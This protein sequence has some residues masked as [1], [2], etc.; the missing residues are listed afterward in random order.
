MASTTT[1][2]SESVITPEQLADHGTLDTLWIAV[3]GRVYDLTNFSSDHPGGIDALESSAGTDGTE[4]YEYAGHS[5]ENMDKMQEYCVGKLAGSLEQV[6]P[7]SFGTSKRIKGAASGLQQLITPRTRLAATIIATSLVGVALSHRYIPSTQDIS[8]PQSTTMLSQNLR[9]AFWA[10]TAV[11][12]SIS[13]VA[14]RYLY[15]L[16]LSSLD[17]QNDVFSFPPTIPRKRR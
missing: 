7:P 1:Q 16:F 15:L 11:V 9:Y 6:L 10:G 14:F 12:S 8:Q 2:R 4:A 13:L 17:H 3:H 5:E